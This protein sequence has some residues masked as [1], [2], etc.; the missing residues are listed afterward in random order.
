MNSLRS[1]SFNSIS[2]ISSCLIFLALYKSSSFAVAISSNI[3]FRDSIV[4]RSS[5]VFYI[6]SRSEVIVRLYSSNSSFSPSITCT[7]SGFATF[8]CYSAMKFRFS[9]RSREFSSFN[10]TIRCYNFADS[11]FV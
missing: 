6:C 4:A 8:F 7:D 10:F 3:S 5:F 11:L 2:S 9:V 1:L